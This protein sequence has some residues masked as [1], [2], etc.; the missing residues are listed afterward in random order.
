I[1]SGSLNLS[2]RLSKAAIADQKIFCCHGVLLAELPSMENL[3]LRHIPNETV[4]TKC[5][6]KFCDTELDFFLS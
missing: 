6:G 1:T 3:N 5:I 4:I 2:S